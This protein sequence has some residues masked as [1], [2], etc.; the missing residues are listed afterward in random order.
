MV[1]FVE[2]FKKIS[3]ILKKITEIKNKIEEYKI[4]KN[5]LTNLSDLA[6]LLRTENDDESGL[7][8]RFTTA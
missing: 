6:E 4:I 5:G 1:F 8:R 2:C 7:D 3:K